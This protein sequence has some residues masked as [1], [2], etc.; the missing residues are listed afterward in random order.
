MSKSGRIKKRFWQ[1]LWQDIWRKWQWA[2]EVSKNNPLAALSSLFL[3]LLIIFLAWWVIFRFDSPLVKNLGF[4]QP[5]WEWMGLLIIP[6]VLALA[7]FFLNK[8]QK[9]SEQHVA[10]RR[11]LEN[12]QR[13]ER[14]DRENR[15]R[16]DEKQSRVTFQEFVDAMERFFLN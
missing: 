3:F 16:D 11:E 13:D 14:R 5:L 4:D 9:E 10:E 1:Y 12:R 2:V 7:A 6:G 8:Q 15:A